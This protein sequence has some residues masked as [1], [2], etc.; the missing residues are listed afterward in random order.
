M[1]CIN[2]FQILWNKDRQVIL[3][4]ACLC[5]Y[6]SRKLVVLQFYTHWQSLYWPLLLCNVSHSFKMTELLSLFHQ[7]FIFHRAYNSVL[8]KWKNS[9]RYPYPWY[10]SLWKHKINDEF[11]LSDSP[12]SSPPTGPTSSS[13]G[14]HS[15]LTSI[16]WFLCTN[17]QFTFVDSCSPTGLPASPHKGPVLCF[18]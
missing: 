10:C 16:L 8:Q 12:Q 3:I 9:W 6:Q 14:N 1:Y 7:V 2:C 13:P 11:V 5:F 17:I 4:Q 15:S 18:I